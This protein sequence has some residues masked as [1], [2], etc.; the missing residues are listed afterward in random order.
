MRQECGVSTKSGSTQ[1]SPLI[2]HK[3]EPDIAA[4]L[5]EMFSMFVIKLAFAKLDLRLI[6]KS[7]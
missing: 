4:L 3:I 7:H 2:V 1:H 6:S 5:Q